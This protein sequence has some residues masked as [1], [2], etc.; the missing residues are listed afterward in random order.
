V[1]SDY[2]KRIKQDARATFDEPH[3]D[4]HSRPLLH[5]HQLPSAEQIVIEMNLLVSQ[6]LVDE[7]MQGTYGFLSNFVHPTLYA[8]QELFSVSDD[9]GKHAPSA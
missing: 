4:E 3:Q 1:R 5:G 2:Y 9:S 8:L 6:P 7:M